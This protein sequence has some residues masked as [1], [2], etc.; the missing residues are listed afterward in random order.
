M[1]MAHAKILLGTGRGTAG[2]RP[3]VEGSH[4]TTGRHGGEAS[5]LHHA[6]AR[7][8]PPPRSVED[9]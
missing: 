3:V 6:A 9:C 2:R 4:V 7:R 1:S 5:P 8:G